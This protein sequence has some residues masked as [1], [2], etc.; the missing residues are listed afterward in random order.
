MK[1]I[2][3]ALSLFTILSSA[4]YAQDAL[5]VWRDSTITIDGKSKDWPSFLRFYISGAKAQFDFCNDSSYLYICIKASDMNAQ[6]RLLHAGI[7]IW[8]DPTGKK[9]TKTGIAFPQKLERAPGDQPHKVRASSDPSSGPTEKSVASR[10]RE[11]VIFAQTSIKVIGMIGVTEQA[12]PMQNKYGIDIAY[13]WDSLNILSIEY[14][15]PLSLIL[16]H[17]VQASDQEHP[18]GLGIVVG[19]EHVARTESSP[20]TPSA[21]Q[22]GQRGGMNQGGRGGNGGLQNNLANDR[23]SSDTEEQ[24]VWLK[25]HLESKSSAQ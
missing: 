8:F 16:Q 24:K 15:I 3:V 19:A 10:L 22:N 11:H 1:K 14:K 5:S 2:A 12:I 4:V 21:G 17:P 7:D 25:V 13:D 20:P 18:L 6:A 9:K 23:F